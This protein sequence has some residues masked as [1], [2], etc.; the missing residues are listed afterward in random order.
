MIRGRKSI[1]PKLAPFI[2]VLALATAMPPSSAHAAARKHRRRRAA[3]SETTATT[4]PPLTQGFWKNH[5]SAWNDGAGLTLGSTFYNNAQLLQILQSSASSDASLIMADQLIAA[6]L[7]IDNGTDG[8]P[9]AETIADANGLLGGGSIPEE[10]APASTLGQQ[11]VNDATILNNFNNGRITTACAAPAPTATPSATPTATPTATA[12]LTATATATPTSTATST[13][14]ATATATAT[15]TAT[16]TATETAT[17][18]VTATPTLTATPTPTPSI[19]GTTG[20]PHLVT[21]DGLHYD[22]QAVGEFV[23]VQS[24]DDSLAVQ[25][26]TKPWPERPVAANSAVAMQIGTDRV[27]IYAD[28]TPS[29]YLNGAQISASMSL[30]AGFVDLSPGFTVVGW[31]DGSEVQVRTNALSGT[32]FYLDVVV[33]LAPGRQGRVVG[34]LAGNGNDDLVSRDGVVFSS[35]LTAGQLYDQFGYSWRISQAE[36]LFDYFNGETTATFTDLLFPNELATADSLPAAIQQQ[37]QTACTQAGVTDPTLLNDCIVDLGFTGDPAFATS[38]ASA[39]VPQGAATVTCSDVEI[40]TTY[41]SG[42][43]DDVGVC[44]NPDTGFAVVTNHG[45]A[46]FTGS[47]SLAGAAGSG[48]SVNSSEVVTLAAGASATLA[49]G[50]EGSNQ[51][52]FNFDASTGLDDGIQITLNGSLDLVPFTLSVFD[53]DIH[54]GVLRTD[55]FGVVSDSYVLQGGDPSGRDTGDSYETTQ[56]PGDFHFCR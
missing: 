43:C 19:G 23:L 14:T 41:H 5:F 38:A 55:P 2:L 15:E 52:G 48:G 4:C 18:T 1:L 25:V 44:A 35:P 22:F 9:I 24:L 51:G 40:T 20:D 16:P 8:T 21:V 13:P 45:P 7:N 34:L 39:P 30:A 12:T 37:A 32:G 3:A 28:P 36:S 47:F 29:V 53:K 27:G 10:V 26:R 31:A 56:A 6:M 50:P 54:S 17:T 11:M 49:A 33:S 42:G 46:T